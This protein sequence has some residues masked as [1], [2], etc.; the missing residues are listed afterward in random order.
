M[1]AHPEAC[2]SREKKRISKSKNEERMKR[3]QITETVGVER[4]ER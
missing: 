4:F 1:G 3:E 2:F